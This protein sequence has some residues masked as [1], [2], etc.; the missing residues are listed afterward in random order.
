M[1]DSCSR[2][3]ASKSLIRPELQR[4]MRHRSLEKRYALVLFSVHYAEM[5]RVSVHF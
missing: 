4:H 2:R 1:P 3:Q 5:P